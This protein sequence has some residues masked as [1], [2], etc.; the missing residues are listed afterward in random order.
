MR[1]EFIH[2][3]LVGC[4]H[5][6]PG[7]FDHH[8]SI[9]SRLILQFHEF[10]E[11]GFKN[12]FQFAA[13]IVIARDALIHLVQIGAIPEFLL[14]RLRHSGCTLHSEHLQKDIPP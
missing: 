11:T 6:A 4:P 5:R 1:F 14:E 13:L 8:R 10:T 9:G 3:A 7:A 12:T 2:L